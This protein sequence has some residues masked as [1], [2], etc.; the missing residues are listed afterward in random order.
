M[1]RLSGARYVWQT[2]R[3]PELTWKSDLLLPLISRARF[4][5][6]KLL[7]RMTGLGFKLIREA[8][9][10]VLVEETV[11]TAAIEG[12]RLEW[13]SV[14]SSVVRHLGMPSAGLPAPSRAVDGLVEVL[15]DATT[16][17]SKPLTAARVKA[18]QAALFPTGY[19][20]LKRIRT[21]KWR[22]LHDPMRVA[23]G[24]IGH[25]KVHYEAP[26]G[27]RVEKEMSRF[28][29]WWTDSFGREEGLLRAG[30]AHFYFVT[31]HPFEDGN[32][33]IARAVTD[34][35]L[36]QD[37]NLPARYYSLSSQIMA[38]RNEYYRILERCQKGGEDVTE[39]LVWFLE[40]Y[41][42]AVEGAGKLIRN[43]LDKATFWH[44][45]ETTNLNER[46]RKVVNRL[47]DA[48]KEGFEGGMTTR[49]YVSLTKVSRVTAY[50]EITELLKKG[51]F[52]QNDAKG[53]SVSYTLRWI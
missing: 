44:Q 51:I 42:R 1:K 10:E 37:E 25:E 27:K 46:Q 48:G 14:R 20:G 18:W 53:R 2:S 33:R 21:G 43:V 31:I 39:W 36:A 32:G 38:E 12:E 41:I 45:H 3:W 9:A 29:S 34:M 5:Q 16:N 52:R 4:E 47:L 23:S 22:G 35:A 8:Q 30:L 26:P 49:K 50:R 24:A 6:G 15:L 28:L 17:Y 40:C 11:K 7:S 19:S 13:T